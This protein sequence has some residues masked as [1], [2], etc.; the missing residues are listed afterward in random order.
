MNISPQDLERN[1]QVF[2]HPDTESGS[3][4]ARHI[5]AL[6]GEDAAAG[7]YVFLS[8]TGGHDQRDDF[9]WV[10]QPGIHYVFLVPL[11]STLN[12]FRDQRTIH[13]NLD[14]KESR[15]YLLGPGGNSSVYGDATKKT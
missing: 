3:G 1:K 4:T 15:L 2:F 10:L 14:Q 12:R 9:S 11:G 5:P 6:R 8:A 7:Q 13:Q